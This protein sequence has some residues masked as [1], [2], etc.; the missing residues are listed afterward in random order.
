MIATATKGSWLQE[1]FPE[2]VA[3]M[4]AGGFALTLGE[5]LLMNHTEK[6]QKL[7]LLMT[8]AGMLAVA[9]GLIAPKFRKLL[10]GVLIV[11]A[12]SGLFGV[13]EHLEEAAEHREKAAREASAPGVL[14][15]GGGDAGE[16]EKKG[17]K[18]G[19]PPLAPLSVS[20]LALMGSLGLLALKR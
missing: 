12:A 4:V 16:H 14:Q 13:Y 20:G 6:I 1:R 11:V 17:E 10:V 2:L 15:A 3:V 18:H 7:A 9:L 19:P 5:L 8:S